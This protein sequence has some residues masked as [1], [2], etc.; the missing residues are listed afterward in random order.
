MAEWAQPESPRRL[1]KLAYSLSTFR[2][3]AIRRTSH[4][5]RQAIMDWQSDLD[6]LYEEFYNGFTF[7]WP[8]RAE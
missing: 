8:E 5:M 1:R 4:D 3:N 6:W 7:P 2:D